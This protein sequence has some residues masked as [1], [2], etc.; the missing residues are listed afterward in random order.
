MVKTKR[1][2]VIVVKAL[3]NNSLDAAFSYSY[4]NDSSS[5]VSD[6]SRGYADTPEFYIGLRSVVVSDGA[7]GKLGTGGAIHAQLTER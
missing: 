6:T 3:S 7:S 4:L 1:A 2:M 5:F